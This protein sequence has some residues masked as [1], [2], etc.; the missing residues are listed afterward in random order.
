MNEVEK[1]LQRLRKEWN[2]DIQNRP[3]IQQK[4]D[5]LRCS[6]GNDDNTRCANLVRGIGYVTCQAHFYSYFKPSQYKSIGEIQSR[7]QDI[8]KEKAA[9]RK[10]KPRRESEILS[11]MYP[12]DNL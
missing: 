5:L 3:A 2:R 10:E 6:Y 4:A 12:I 7:I 11:D 1:E 9:K 8:I